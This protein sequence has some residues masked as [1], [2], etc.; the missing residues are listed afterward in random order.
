MTKLLTAALIAASLSGCVTRDLCYDEYVA[1]RPVGMDQ[2]SNEYWD[3]HLRT[4]RM[5][6]V[7]INQ[8][9]R[10]SIDVYIRN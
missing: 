1:K 4:C 5:M 9:S 3:Y 10:P 7:L 8:P 2:A 6:E